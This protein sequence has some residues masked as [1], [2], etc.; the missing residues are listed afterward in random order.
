MPGAPDPLA[1]VVIPP[2]EG[3]GPGRV[4]AV[5]MIVLGL[6]A[7]PGFRTIVLGG[8]RAGPAFA[9]VPFRAVRPAIWWRSNVNL[10]FAAAALAAAVVLWRLKPV[11]LE[12]HN[13]P[14][15]ALALA[16]LFPR[17]PV[18]LMLHND[19]QDMRAASSP[20]DRTKLLRHLAL[21]ATGSA[22]LRGRFRDGVNVPA[23][24]IALLANCIDFAE[25]LARRRREWLVL[26]AGRVVPEKGPDII[27]AACA[28]SLPHLSGWHGEIIGADGFLAD[29]PDANFV[30]TIRVAAEGTNVRMTGYCDHPLV[31]D[32]MARAAIVVVPSRW[33]EPFGLTAPEA[34]ASGAALICSARGGLSE[35]AGNAAGYV[36]PDDP[37]AIAGAIRGLARDPARRVALTELGLIRARQF[38][39]TAAVSRL[40]APAAGGHRAC[41]SHGR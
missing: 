39:V 22:Y 24:R 31:L 21:V 33:A 4:G 27:V 30:R 11:L 36:D 17:I 12:A 34:M 20:A 6:A 19:P 38:D 35:V 29:S 40:P 3:F 26:F 18:A 9:D 14:E 8:P 2:R 10:Q 7:T 25:L 16:R 5:G 23:E 1:A 41:R 13:R 32:A 15:V 37:D 28:A